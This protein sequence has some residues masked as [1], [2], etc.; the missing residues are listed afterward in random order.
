MNVSMTAQGVYVTCGKRT[1]LGGSFLDAI[2]LLGFQLPQAEHFTINSAKVRQAQ[3]MADL[4]GEAQCL[5]KNFAGGI[6]I[7]RESKIDRIVNNE[8]LIC[9]VE[10][11]P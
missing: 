7:K 3:H 10:P 6:D 8:N 11:K 2:R 1:A 4:T 9:I 5:V